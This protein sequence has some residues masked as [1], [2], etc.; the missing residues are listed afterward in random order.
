M[1]EYIALAVVTSIV[2]LLMMKY[3]EEKNKELLAQRIRVRYK[4][5]KKE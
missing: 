5:N 1:W 4:K 2:L 3:S